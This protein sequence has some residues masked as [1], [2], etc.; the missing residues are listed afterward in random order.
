VQKVLLDRFI[1]GLCT[2]LH[3]S[4]DESRVTPE[5]GLTELGIDSLVAVEIRSWFLSELDLDMP[6][7]KI[8][9][10]ASIE[11][12]VEDAF[13]RLSPELTPEFKR[14]GQVVE[15]EAVQEKTAPTEENYQ[16]ETLLSSADVSDNSS[17]DEEEA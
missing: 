16:S 2:M 10:G 14:E 8:L 12:M 1:S 5:T 6:V 7:L 9:S 3:I 15:V 11:K 13:E 17:S 4:E